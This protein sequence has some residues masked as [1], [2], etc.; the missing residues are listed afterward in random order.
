[1]NQLSLFSFIIGVICAYRLPIPNNFQEVTWLS[2]LCVI[3]WQPSRIRNKLL[4]FMMGLLVVWIS[5]AW[6]ANKQLPSEQWKQPI[7]VTVEIIREMQQ[8]GFGRRYEA[9]VDNQQTIMLA[10]YAPTSSLMPGHCYALHG[11]FKPKFGAYAWA[12]K[13]FISG[14]VD[15]K[16]PVQAIPC[17]QAVWFY[18]RWRE[19]LNQQL[20]LIPDKTSRALMQALGLGIRDG[21][22]S[23]HWDVFTQTGTGHLMAISGM[24]IGLLYGLLMFAVYGALRLISPIVLRL[25]MKLCAQVIALM[26]S[27]LYVLL[28]GAGV[29]AIRAWMM[30]TLFTFMSM[31]RERLQS[32]HLLLSVL[33]IIL[34]LDPMAGLGK[35]LWLSVGAVAILMWTGGE[36]HA[37]WLMPL[38][39]LPLTLIWFEASAVSILANMIAIPWVAF[40]IMPSLLI[41]LCANGMGLPGV[42]WLSEWVV[43]H[44]SH[45]WRLLEQLSSVA[46]MHA[47]HA[48]IWEVVLLFSLMLSLLLPAYWITWRV[49]AVLL[50][51]LLFPAL[52]SLPDDE[53]LL[54]VLDVGQGLALLIQVGEKR[55]LYDTGPKWEGGDSARTTVLPHLKK[56]HIKKID[57][58]VISHADNDHRGGLE[59]ILKH[60]EVG[61][62]YVGEKLD[63]L[64]G[65]SQTSCAHPASWQWGE[66]H[67]EFLNHN[68]F[69]GN[70]ASC[71][72]RVSI[73]DTVL[74]VT[75]DI[76]RRAEKVLLTKHD[77][78]LLRA[79]VLIAP[80]HGSKT[81]SSVSFLNAVLPRVV[82]YPTGFLNQF[83]HPHPDIVTRYDKIQTKQYSTAQDGTMRVK[84]SKNGIQELQCTRHGKQPWWSRQE[85]AACSGFL[86]QVGS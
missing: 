37:K 9:R 8:A 85:E 17:K 21:L 46:T 79:D 69:T 52:P 7:P 12:N 28:T 18:Q 80:H 42:D 67:F 50:L 10:H 30:L 51:A 5:Y 44:L 72:L 16:Q 70:N 25:N 40:I 4:F 35:G 59:T 66:V 76:E 63:G 62:L 23:Q 81:S 43:F 56:H 31:R 54:D 64:A 27:G 32:F 11:K 77:E 6:H 33:A 38:Y 29:T 3:V 58:L 68:D 41:L 34:L 47:W 45:L 2:L 15:A 39:M 75:G 26:L 53:I 22:Q 61:D 74:L 57:T 49:R 60:M 24:H 14:Y 13:Q 84:L 36:R 19:A 48:G 20:L 78:S 83:N 65:L 86:Q 1:M 55:L 82:I 73:E 71:V